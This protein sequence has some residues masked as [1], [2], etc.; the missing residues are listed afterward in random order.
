MPSYPAPAP[1]PPNT[2]PYQVVAEIRELQTPEGR[3][4]QF[5]SSSAELVDHAWLQRQRLLQLSNGAKAFQTHWQH[6]D[7]NHSVTEFS[8]PLPTALFSPESQV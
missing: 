7:G 3:I 2:A 5:V 4:W 8:P 6:S 1:L